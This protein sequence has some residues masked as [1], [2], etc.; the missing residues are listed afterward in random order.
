[1]ARY[2]ERQIFRGHPVPIIHDADELFA[3]GSE[4]NRNP[5]GASIERIFDKFLDGGCRP[6]DHFAS[7]DTIDGRVV[8]LANN[9][10]RLAYVGVGGIHSTIGSTPRPD[11]TG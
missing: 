5:P 10:A 6:F 11:S 2:G 7:R 9:G 4:S 3:P 1:M 8:K